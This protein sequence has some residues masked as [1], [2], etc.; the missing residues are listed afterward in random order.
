MPITSVDPH[1][2]AREQVGIIALDHNG[3]IREAD[4]AE[5]DLVAAPE[6]NGVDIDKALAGILNHIENDRAQRVAWLMALEC[7]VPE[8]AEVLGMSYKAGHRPVTC[9]VTSILTYR[10]STERLP[11]GGGVRSVPPRVST[12]D[13]RGPDALALPDRRVRPLASGGA[14][15]R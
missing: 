4:V 10:W 12:G 3:T 5:A 13:T 8:M 7:N 2:A 11:R 14:A 9:V 1:P 6:H 15:W